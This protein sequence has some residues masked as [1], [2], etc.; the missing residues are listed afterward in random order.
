MG[1]SL[2]SIPVSVSGRIAISVQDQPVDTIPFSI[3]QI[4]LA[5]THGPLDFQLGFEGSAVARPL[6]P[7]DVVGVSFEDVNRYRDEEQVSDQRVST[8][9]SGS[10]GLTIGNRPPH[11]L[12]KGEE[13]RLPGFKGA[14]RDI[15]VDSQAV[16]LTLEGTVDSLPASLGKVPNVLQVF[17]SEHP[18]ASTGAGLVYLALF[19]LVG[20][21]WKRGT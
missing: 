6:V 4:Q 1:D 7:L 17:W 13:L 9:D 19:V 18:L 8:I 21:Y 15:A 14:V 12:K 3:D 16:A 10:L 20:L 5:A 2:P 11:T